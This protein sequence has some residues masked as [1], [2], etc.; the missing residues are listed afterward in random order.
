MHKQD[1]IETKSKERRNLSGVIIKRHWKYRALSP[2][3]LGGLNSRF[4]WEEMKKKEDIGLDFL[5]FF[6]NQTCAGPDWVDSFDRGN[7]INA[8]VFE[9][10]ICVKIEKTHKLNSKTENQL[11]A[12]TKNKFLLWEINLKWWL[13]LKKTFQSNIQSKNQMMNRLNSINV[14]FLSSSLAIL[15]KTPTRL[16]AI[17]IE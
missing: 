8:K 7:K 10:T 12:Q 9:K 3:K 5:I 4:Q 13:K 1:T 14:I 6:S 2:N 16:S 15:T 17:F 11:I